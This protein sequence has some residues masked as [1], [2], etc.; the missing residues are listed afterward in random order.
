MVRCADPVRL[1]LLV[2][3]ALGALAAWLRHRRRR[4]MQQRLA[5]PSVWRQ[6]MGG[7]PATG[8]GRMVSWC[9]AAACIVLALARPQWGERPRQVEMR[10]RDIVC[11]IDVSASMRCQDVHPSRLAQGLALI[12]HALPDLDGNRIGVVTFAGDAYPLVPLTTDLDAVGTFLEAVEPGSI[13]LPGSNIERAADAGIELLPPAGSGRVL[14]LVTDGENLQGHLDAAAKRLKAAGVKVL[15]IVVGTKAGGPIPV[16]GPDGSIRYKRTRDGQLVITHAHRETL[17][18][19]ASATG[20]SVFVAGQVGTP[21]ALADAI[22]K[23]QSRKMGVTRARRLVERFP[24]FLGAA[25]F[26][27]ALGFVLSPW[28]KA[29]VLVAIISLLPTTVLLARPIT[30]QRPARQSRQAPAVSWWQR[31]LPGG[32]RRLARA[33]LSAWKRHEL[34]KAAKAF[35]QAAS[36]DPKNPARL[37]D[38]GTVLAARGDLA[39]AAPLLGTA[40]QAGLHGAEYNLG[41]AALEHH[42]VK[43]AVRFLRSALLE[44]PHDPKVKRNYELAL[45]MLKKQR[46]KKAKNNTPKHKNTARRSRPKR[47]PRPQVHQHPERMPVNPV[48]G[49]LERAEEQARKELRRPK[50]KPVTVEKDW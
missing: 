16:P 4:F 46:T 28:R 3:P 50:P 5:S 10:T 30:P 17:M 40:A 49:A 41:T 31:W 18:K 2:L 24:I 14:V 47:R 38:L 20:G 44:R 15:G 27:L 33:G 42:Q 23:L 19:L 39:H 37:Y 22:A 32:S 36:L 48:F 26:F 29:V 9:V 45:K 11:A 43:A 25:A 34:S 6:V 8:L 21:R 12:R 13:A 35:A 1:V 7:V